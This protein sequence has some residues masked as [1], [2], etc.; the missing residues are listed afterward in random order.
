MKLYCNIKPGNQRRIMKKLPIIAAFMF[1]SPCMIKSAALPSAGVNVSNSSPSILSSSVVFINKTNSE[2]IVKLVNLE[3]T[4]EEVI[5]LLQGHKDQ[6][7][8]PPA[9]R[10]PLPP[11]LYALQIVYAPTGKVTTLTANAL[12]E[13]NSRSTMCTQVTLMPGLFPDSPQIALQGCPS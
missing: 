11:G 4:Q 1:I 13:S 2:Y 5:E 12:R 6:Q 7:A 3:S 9:L 10:L 8:A